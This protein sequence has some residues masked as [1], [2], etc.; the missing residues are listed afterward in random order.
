MSQTQAA[1]ALDLDPEEFFRTND[2]A[3]A[4]FLKLNSHSVQRMTWVGGTCYW[5]FRVT[6]DLL[7]CVEEFTAGEARVEPREYNRVF[8]QTKREFYDSKP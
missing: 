8:T 1:V 4:T 7:E 5:I 2:M 3:M 6:D